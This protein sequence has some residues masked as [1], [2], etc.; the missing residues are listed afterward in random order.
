MTSRMEV[1][2]RALAKMFC[3]DARSQFEKYAPRIIRCL[4][5]L[6]EKEI[7]WR[8]NDA[9]NAA[10]NIV[11]H[12]CGNLR[13]WIISGL[14]GAPDFR[15]RDKE[16]SERGPVPRRVLISQLKRTVK[17]TC[18]TINRASVKTLSRK[19]EIQGF[20]VSGLVAIAHVYEHFRVSHRPD[21]LSHEVETRTRP[22]IY[23]SPAAE[24]VS[25]PAVRLTPINRQPFLA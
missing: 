11:L 9:S 4:Q 24:T 20:R 7:W 10:G 13:Q 23:A 14:S 2:E 15:E 19:F 1:D 12:L 21:H 5:L 8:P 16:F 6:N 25:A 17:E 22:A 3:E 18:K